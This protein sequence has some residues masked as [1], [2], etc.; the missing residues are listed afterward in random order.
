VNKKIFIAACLLALIALF[1]NFQF[2]FTQESI[3]ADSI[4]R[5]ILVVGLAGV[6]LATIALGK[7]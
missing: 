4:V 5:L 1:L 2:A 7:T 3:T 6:V